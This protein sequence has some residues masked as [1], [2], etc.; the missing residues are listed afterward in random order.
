MLSNVKHR[1]LIS[2]GKQKRVFDVH[3]ELISLLYS[4]SDEMPYQNEDRRVSQKNDPF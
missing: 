3:V 4:K 1:T 2:K